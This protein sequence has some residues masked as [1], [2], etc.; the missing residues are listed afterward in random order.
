MHIGHGDL[1]GIMSFSKKMRAMVALATVTGLLGLTACGGGN[2]VSPQFASTAVPEAI[3]ATAAP[4]PPTE[5][6]VIPTVAPTVAP[7]LAGKESGN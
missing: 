4:V 2:D 6:S 1:T 7:T 3:A 5:I